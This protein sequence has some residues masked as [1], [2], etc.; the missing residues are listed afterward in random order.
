MLIV[1]YI[2][3]RKSPRIK[4]LTMGLAVACVYARLDP[5]RLHSSLQYLSVAAR[6]FVKAWSA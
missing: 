1:A 3:L 4:C 5:L 2:N 6:F